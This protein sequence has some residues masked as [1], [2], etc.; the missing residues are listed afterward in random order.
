MTA[1]MTHGGSLYPLPYF[2]PKSAL[3]CID[4]EHITCFH[5][6]P[7]MFIALLEHPDFA[8]TDFRT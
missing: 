6:V 3:S 4:R 7:T 2:S 8:K 1:A 5:G